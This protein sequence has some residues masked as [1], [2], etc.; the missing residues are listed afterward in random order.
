MWIES[1]TT[2][3]ADHQQTG[4]FRAFLPGALRFAGKPLAVCM[5][6]LCITHHHHS[7]HRALRRM[8]AGLVFLFDFLGA[9]GRL[10][11]AKGTTAAWAGLL[12]NSSSSI[13]II[14]LLVHLAR[15]LCTH[16]RPPPFRPQRR[17]LVRSRVSDQ[18]NLPRA[19]VFP[20]GH[21]RF[22]A[23]TAEVIAASRR[24]WRRSLPLGGGH[25]GGLFTNNTKTTH[26]TASHATSAFPPPQEPAL[27]LRFGLRG[28]CAARR[29]CNK[30]RRKITKTSVCPRSAPRVFV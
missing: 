22:A 26:K 14:M 10:P 5:A 12:Y 24:S 25:G 29:I 7:T 15:E 2:K 23:V 20:S 18:C 1:R 16:L 19:A 11:K 6:G 13:I 8:A 27:G 28:I 17:V 3:L 9:G 4:S 30:N 21:C